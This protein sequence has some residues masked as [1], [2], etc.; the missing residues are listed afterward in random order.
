[1]KNNK[2]IFLKRMFEYRAQYVVAAIIAFGAFITIINGFEWLRTNIDEGRYIN[3]LL[4]NICI[5]LI[6]ATF[7]TVTYFCSKYL[8]KKYGADLFGD[9]DQDWLKEYQG[10]DSSAFG[11]IFTRLIQCRKIAGPYF[12]GIIAISSLFGE[13][14]APIASVIYCAIYILYR[15]TYLENAIADRIPRALRE[16]VVV[17]R[18]IDRD[19][20][21]KID[22]LSK[23]L[24]QAKKE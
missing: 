19:F 1:M 16:S 17:S 10:F 2:D 7:N 22:Q 4:S 14:F 21:D 9:L 3:H 18:I 6:F 11:E 20:T 23:D 12:L 13:V 8:A 15:V 5:F 24:K